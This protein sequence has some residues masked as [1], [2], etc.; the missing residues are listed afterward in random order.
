MQ[1]MVIEF[2]R[3]VC[4]LEDANSTEFDPGHAASRDLQTAR[5]ERRRRTGR[6]HAPGRLSLPAGR[7]QLRPHKPTARARSASAIGIATNS[8]ASIEGTLT[9]RG[10]RHHRRNAGRHLRRDLR[11]RRSSLVSRL[12]VPSR[13]QV[14]AA[15]AASAVHGR[16]S[17]PRCEHRDS[18]TGIA[19]HGSANCCAEP[20]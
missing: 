2:A 4:G 20:H 11:D 10:L 13:V 12:P 6:H 16:S 5:I 7:R 9:S 3:N 18:T 17:A 8:I 14:Q 1:T 15:G 19:T